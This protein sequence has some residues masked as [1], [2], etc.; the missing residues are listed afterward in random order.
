MYDS[1]RPEQ[2]ADQPTAAAYW[3]AVAATAPVWGTGWED[4]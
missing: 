3:A 2:P 4:R 1:S